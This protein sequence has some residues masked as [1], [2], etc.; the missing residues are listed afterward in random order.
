MGKFSGLKCQIPRLL[1]MMTEGVINVGANDDQ[2][3]VS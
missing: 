1:E 3:W 2:N